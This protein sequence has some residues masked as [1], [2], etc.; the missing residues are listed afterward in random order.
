MLIV[1]RSFNRRTKVFKCT[2][3]GYWRNVPISSELKSLLIEIKQKAKGEFVRPH[4]RDWKKGGQAK[5]LKSF[6]SFIGIQPI[7]FHTLRACFA[8]QLIADGAEPTKIMKICG[9]RDLKTMQ[10]YVRLAGIDERGATERLRFLPS[11]NGLLR[12]HS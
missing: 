11:G 6:C 2:K 1:Q 12:C 7:K 5:V 10:R 4:F 8:T 9:W 3:A